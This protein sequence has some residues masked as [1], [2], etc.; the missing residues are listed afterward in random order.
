V[1]ERNVLTL[2][3]RY[4]Q[5]E[6]VILLSGIQALVRLP[7]DQHRA[8]ARRGLKTATL[9]SGY[10]G[11]PL[12]GYD[13][14]LQSTRKLL[15]QHQ[16][17]FIPG[18][19]E[20][21]GATAIF[22]SQL[23]NL[24][25]NPKY[26]GVLGVW[27]G[28]SPGVDRSGDI[29]KHANFAGVGRNGGVLALAGDDP[30]CSS[31]TLPSHSE[32]ALFDALMPVVYPGNIQELLDFGRIGF[33]M[34]RYS[35]LWVGFKITAD[36]A[37][38][39]GTA[40]VSP[41]RVRLNSPVFS[42]S[43]KPWAAKQSAALFPPYSLE[44]ERQMFEGR[45]EAARAFGAAN[46]LN[47][48]TLATPKAW[49]GI[50]A[51]GKT[52]YDVREALSQIGL[53][54]DEVIRHRGIRLFRVGLLYPMDRE[55][56]R[57]FALGLEQILVIEEKRGF[58]E[59]MLRDLLYGTANPPCIIGK[60]NE[61][62]E[63]LV[64]AWG[65]LDSDRIAK[66]L[67][68][69]LSARFLDQSMAL[70]LRSLGSISEQEGLA[71]Q[72]RQSF[73]CSGCPHN[74]S[75]NVPAGSIAA[76]GIGCH[77]MALRLPERRT[78]GIT[79]MGGEG[80]QWVGMAPFTNIPHIFQNVGDGTFYHSG[81]LAVRQAVVA[82]TNITFKILYNSAVGMTGGQKVD[83]EASVP[84]LTRMLEAEGV[85][86]I[87]VTSDE[88]NKYSKHARWTPGV[89][90]WDRTRLDEAQRLLREIHGV[91]VIIHD[92]TCAAE[93]R[94]MR[95]RG[96]IA[97]RATRV[98][99][100]ERV[101]EGC[102]DCGEQSNCLSVQ[103]IETE[104]GRKTQ[105]HQ[106]S[107][108]KDYSCVLGDCPS[109]V[110][111]EACEPSMTRGLP[112]QVE[113]P[114]PEPSRNV[115]PQANILLAGIGGTGVVTISQI[116]GTAALFDGKYVA[117][118]DQT[119][120]SQKA[121]SVFSHVKI[122]S[123]PARESAKVS[124]SN[125]DCF[126]AFDLLTACASPALSRLAPERT[127]AIVSTSN[128]PTGDM[129]RST[130]VNFPPIEPLVDT[131]RSRT[132]ADRLISFDAAHLSDSLFGDHIA[133]N[134][135]T[136]GAAYQAGA[137]PISADSIEKAITLN[138]VAIEMNISAFRVGRLVVADP[139]C[140]TPRETRKTSFTLATILSLNE[141][142]G[143]INEINAAGELRRLLEIRV[144]ELISY[145]SATYA[146]L[147]VDFVARV[148]KAEDRA[149]PG[150]TALREAVARYLYKLMAYKDEYEVARLHLQGPVLRADAPQV[151]GAMRFRYLISPPVLR[152]LGVN[153]KISVGD[154]FKWVFWI[155]TRL[156]RLRGT[157]LDPFGYTEIRRLE[158]SLVGEYRSLVEKQLASL[159]PITHSRSVKAASLPELIRGY[160]EIKLASVQRFRREAEVLETV[161][162]SLDSCPD[163]PTGNQG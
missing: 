122:L 163:T 97:D 101:C 118:L 120:L 151:F 147:Y 113:Q 153:K 112:F 15:E 81:S 140:L 79:H 106:S 16:I 45:V 2:D 91:T 162:V 146:R 74:T 38:G 104:F 44:L 138:G 124:I 58:L 62:D 77:G 127:I 161:S 75:T 94:R 13:L 37:D 150:A 78:A 136:L 5:E 82:G 90:I 49:L 149:V 43:G 39:F 27:Y 57:E 85:K 144:P 119:G 61:F 17:T 148:A 46:G 93:L 30:G 157:W 31:S 54:D 130:A 29:F 96:R 116:I 28:K 125:C 102:G 158:R 73:F 51:P 160:E 143:I 48:I 152:V 123:E 1:Q 35:G 105:I 4:C 41:D 72:T 108:N 128:Q 24:Y 103:P 98:W 137:L 126:L 25:P 134:M 107:C 135:I 34:S 33:E 83:G 53:K 32:V 19:N 55:I 9:I 139:I 42:V 154:W 89:E 142:Q 141:A 60:R 10:R 68:A 121:G 86:R 6:G 159:S 70:R 155:L 87:I 84:D 133:A 100:N 40:E 129:V 88:P 76:G 3:A 21:L 69:R 95:K 8:D 59:L 65:T 66:I 50:V 7:I 67:I 56:V 63:I 109:F 114:I 18:L 111:F 145:Q 117:G 23:A 20:D 12:A 132:R 80:A 36:L 131:I 26:D 99:I 115:S 64:P 71:V 92:Q 52:Y 110:T 14:A 11:S 47:T 22:G 156:K